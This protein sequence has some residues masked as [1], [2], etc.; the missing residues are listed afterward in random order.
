MLSLF[1]TGIVCGALAHYVICLT[2][3][4]F[5]LRTGCTTRALTYKKQRTFISTTLKVWKSEGTATKKVE[6]WDC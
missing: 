5:V 1:K 4:R 2:I 3:T 6:V